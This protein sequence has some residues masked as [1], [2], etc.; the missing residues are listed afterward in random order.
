MSGKL[1]PWFGRD[2]EIR[3]WSHPVAP[4]RKTIPCSSASRRGQD[5]HV[6]GLAQRIVRGDVPEGLKDARSS[7]ST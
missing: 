4:K 2:T 6:E 5:R 3:T 7:R 1:T